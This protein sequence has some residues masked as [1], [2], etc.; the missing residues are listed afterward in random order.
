MKIIW[1]PNPLRTV[2]KLDN[3]DRWALR[4]AMQDD[5]TSEDSEDNKWMNDLHDEYERSLCDVHVGDCTC[6]PCSCLKCWAEYY[7]GIDTIRGLNKYMAHQIE[8][9]FSGSPGR[10]I[11]E[12]IA[13]LADYNPKPSSPMWDGRRETWEAWLPKWRDDARQA[14]EWLVEYRAECLGDEEPSDRVTDLATSS[15]SSSETTHSA[16]DSA[17]S[18][19]VRGGPASDA[20]PTENP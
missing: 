8:N 10:T 11:D 16:D 17:P 6:V 12:A 1:S 9:A 7:L 14:H 4:E 3:A 13:A 19:E 5:L 15:Q 18:T 2:V 20:P